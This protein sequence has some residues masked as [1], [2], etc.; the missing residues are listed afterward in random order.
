MEFYTLK[1]FCLFHIM[2]VKINNKLFTFQCTFMLHLTVGSE[3]VRFYLKN[4]M[5][6]RSR[7]IEKQQSTF[8]IE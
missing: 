2:Y 6:V 1:N 7:F 5:K 3:K 4:K 8:Q